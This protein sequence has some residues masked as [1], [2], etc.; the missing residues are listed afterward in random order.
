[1]DKK[2]TNSDPLRKSTDKHSVYP[3]L[4]NTLWLLMAVAVTAALVSDPSGAR[5]LFGPTRWG[6]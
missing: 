4:V 3:F 5:L 6:L 2:R 1:M